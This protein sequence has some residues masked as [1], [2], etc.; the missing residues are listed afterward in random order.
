MVKSPLSMSVEIQRRVSECMRK[1][2]DGTHSMR[3]TVNPTVLD[4]LRKEDEAAL[5]ALEEEF[6][7]H[8]TFVSDSH[9]HMEEF[10]ITN[11]DNGKVLF[12]SI[13]A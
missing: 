5:I 13:E 8:L 4:R 9:F 11:D 2:R 3:V 1:D 10:S 6:Q 12:T 7:G